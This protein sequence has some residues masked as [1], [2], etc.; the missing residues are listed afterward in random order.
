[1]DGSASSRQSID[2]RRGANPVVCCLKLINC[3]SGTSRQTS[4][5]PRYEP[6][7]TAPIGVTDYFHTG[8]RDGDTRDSDLCGASPERERDG[9][10]SSRQSMDPRRAPE[11]AARPMP[12]INNLQPQHMHTYYTHIIYVY[13]YIHIHIYTHLYI[14]YLDEDTVGYIGVCDQEQGV[15]EWTAQHLPASPSTRAAVPTR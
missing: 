9:S 13:I 7:S 5:S 1:M 8:E 15:I 14:N 4:S 6:S 12:R 2:P 11:D 3:E 10:A